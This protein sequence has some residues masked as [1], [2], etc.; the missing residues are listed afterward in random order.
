TRH[1]LA[2][3]HLKDVAG[4]RHVGQASHD[5]RRRGTCVLHLATAVIE[6]GPNLAEDE[7][8]DEVV[9]D[10]QRAA[11]HQHGGDGATTYLEAGGNYGNG[12]HLG[13]VHLEVLQVGDQQDH[14]EQFRNP[15]LLLGGHGNHDGLATPVLRDEVLHGE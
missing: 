4:G 7:T 10:V 13:R 15:G 2:G 14:L 11:L 6:Q 1:L 5:G 3:D 8:D 12:A 9:Y